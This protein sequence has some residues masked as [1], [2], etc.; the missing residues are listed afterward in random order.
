M[1]V[2]SVKH[3]LIL[4]VCGLVVLVCLLVAIVVRQG[5]RIL[6]LEGSVAHSQATGVSEGSTFGPLEVRDMSGRVQ[7]IEFKR[8]N[9]KPTVV[10]IFRPACRWCQRNAPNVRALAKHIPS[11]YDIIGLSLVKTDLHDF[12]QREDLGFPVYTDLAA[13]AIAMYRL[14]ST[15]ETLVVS[16]EGKVIKDWIGAYI[17]EPIRSTVEQFFS[18]RFQ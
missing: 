18:L 15:P 2:A 8:P 6:L 1:S 7:L 17:Q 10:Y 13:S 16:P 4:L 11:K 5:Q 9:S 12:I 3:L 14:G